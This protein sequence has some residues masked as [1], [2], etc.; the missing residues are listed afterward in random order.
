VIYFSV[1]QKTGRHSL[2]FLVEIPSHQKGTPFFRVA[3]TFSLKGPVDPPLS[4]MF[5][6]IF[7]FSRFTPLSR[8]SQVPQAYFFPPFSLVDAF[9]EMRWPFPGPPP[10]FLD[11]TFR[12]LP[13]RPEGPHKMLQHYKPFSALTI[14]HFRPVGFSFSFRAVTLIPVPTLWALLLFPLLMA[15]WHNDDEKDSYTTLLP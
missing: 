13:R 2:M 1:I 14:S 8:L 11:E 9:Q 7:S 3:S 5:A 6:S 15:I 4:R 10:F 12:T